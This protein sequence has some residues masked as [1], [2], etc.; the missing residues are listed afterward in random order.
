MMP[1]R[2]AAAHL[3]VLQAEP[4]RRT[5]T[6]TLRHRACDTCDGP[7]SPGPTWTA[8]GRLSVR[9]RRHRARL[10]TR[11]LG[12]SRSPPEGRPFSHRAWRSTQCRAGLSPRAR[13]RRRARR[14]W[15]DPKERSSFLEARSA[16]LA[17]GRRQC[18]ET[19][20]KTEEVERLIA[21]ILETSSLGRGSRDQA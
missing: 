20:G 3:E 14:M 11:R 5:A 2:G 15:A 21:T 16:L 13:G 7:R 10:C 8:A 17:E 4:R 1:R 19:L 6:R 18:R 12:T 9:V